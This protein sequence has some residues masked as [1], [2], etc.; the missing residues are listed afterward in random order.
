MIVPHSYYRDIEQARRRAWQ[1]RKW[2]HERDGGRPQLVWVDLHDEHDKR[3]I[4][5]AMAALAK[6]LKSR[7]EGRA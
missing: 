5:Q 2:Q 3:G 7:T 1:L 4:R 6:G